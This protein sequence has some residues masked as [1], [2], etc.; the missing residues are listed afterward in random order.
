MIQNQS[1]KLRVGILGTRGIPNNYGG[2][3]RWAEQLSAGLVRRNCQ[4]TVYNSH[5]HPYQSKTYKGVSIIKKWDPK[6][7]GLVSQFIYD[8]L[9]VLNARKQK[10]DVIIQLGYTTSSVWAWLLPKKVKI[11]YNM[12]GMEW[13]REKYKGLLKTYLK[14]AEKWAVKYSDVIIADSEPIKHYLDNKYNIH[15][16]FVAYPAQVFNNPDEKILDKFNLKRENYYLLI[17]R[18]QPDNN[19][20]LII[21]GV[22]KSN[23]S[24]QL[25]VVGDY[26]N[27]YGRY[28]RKKYGDKRVVFLGKLYNKLELD[29]L[30]YYSAIYFHGH[31][32]GGTNPSLLEAMATNCLVCAHD[33]EFNYSVLENNAYYFKNELQII[34]VLNDFSGK[35][36]K[37]GWIKNNLDKLHQHYKLEDIIDKYYKLF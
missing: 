18:F 24:K 23:T 11:I 4:V 17:A 35:E 10:F 14:K 3:E 32:A 25:V 16:E 20:E 2:F 12:D 13:Q 6:G 33:N 5:F 28:L 29:N 9:C 26:H 8:L 36:S 1:H 7:F 19:L 15:S 34:A 27:R 31:S 30:R 21:K 37:K 22:L